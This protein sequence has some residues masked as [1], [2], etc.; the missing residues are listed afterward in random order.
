M[1]GHVRVGVIGT[2]SIA[3]MIH[4][5][6]LRDLAVDVEA[7]AAG[8]ADERLDTVRLFVRVVVPHQLTGLELQ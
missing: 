5:P 1:D 7:E 6:F 3:Q 8:Q 2:G 4:L